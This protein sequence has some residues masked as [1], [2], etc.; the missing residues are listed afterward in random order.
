MSNNTISNIAGGLV[1]KLRGLTRNKYHAVGFSW[2][3]EI[4]VKHLPE[5]G[6]R[7]ISLFGKQ[8]TFNGSGNLLHSL[9][10]LFLEDIY[11]QSLKEHAYILDCGAN[12]GLS[13]IYLKRL[14]PTATIVAFEPDETNYSLL[15]KN[16]ESFGLTDVE[17][18]KAA[19]WTE[20]TTLR[21]MSE[22]SLGSRIAD[23]SGGQ[24]VQVRAVRLKDYLD[25]PVDFLKIDIEGAEYA[26]LKDVG[27]RIRLAE[28][29]FIEY[30]GSYTQN[31]EL[32][33]IL[34]WVV[35]HGF[36]YYIKEAGNMHAPFMHPGN[37][38]GFDVQLNIFCTRL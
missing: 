4:M 38:G 33:D 21:F 26:V 5:Q 15:K 16:I 24:P 14:C 18:V 17:A 19:V 10:E 2:P 29:V 6:I 31:K 13:V 32:N 9:Q 37:P 20:E 36:R 23:G 28:K 3:K 7:T 30:H 25:R 35:E 22:G 12:I 1:R 27:D 11:Q 8:L 34:Q